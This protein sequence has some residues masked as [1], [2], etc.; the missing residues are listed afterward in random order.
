MEDYFLNMAK[1]KIGPS[2][3][4]FINQKGRGISNT[5]KAKAIYRI[6]NKTGGRSVGNVISPIEQGII[7]AKADVAMKKRLNKGVKK[8]RNHSTTKHRSGKKEKKQRRGASGKKSGSK[9]KKHKTSSA[10]KNKDVFG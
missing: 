5:R 7:Q 6:P 9:A 3:L 1:G 10:G 2:E 8:V 4:Y